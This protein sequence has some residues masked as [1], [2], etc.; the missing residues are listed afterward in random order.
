MN[1]RPSRIPTAYYSY[2]YSY[3]EKTYVAEYSPPL[4]SCFV[5]QVKDLKVPG[6][7]PLHQSVMV[8][9]HRI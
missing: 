5:H 3:R 1:K 4:P 2:Y 9:Q 7:H 8:L 6:V